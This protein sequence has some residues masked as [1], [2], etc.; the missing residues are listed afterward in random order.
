MIKIKMNHIQYVFVRATNTLLNGLW[1]N[2][3]KENWN[4]SIEKHMIYAYSTQ[5]PYRYEWIYCRLSAMY[6]TIFNFNGLKRD[7]PFKNTYSTHIWT[8]RALWAISFFNL[9]FFALIVLNVWEFKATH[10]NSQ[11]V[12]YPHTSKATHKC[13]TYIR[14]IETK[15]TTKNKVKWEKL[16]KLRRDSIASIL[17]L[18]FCR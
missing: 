7:R 17:V 5:Y 8:L 18:K 1:L 15:I 13:I 11:S 14:I 4:K 3:K 9:Y 2:K 6:V 16:K 12:S 10:E